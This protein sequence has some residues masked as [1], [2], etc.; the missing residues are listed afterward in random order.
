[1]RKAL[2]G[3]GRVREWLVQSDDVGIE[4]APY[5]VRILDESD[6]PD[7]FPRFQGLLAQ[8]RRIHPGVDLI[9]DQSMDVVTPR[10]AIHIALPVLPDPPREIRRDANVEGA[11]WLARQHVDTGNPFPT[12]RGLSV[13]RRFSCRAL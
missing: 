6:L 2:S 5:R 11:S 3:V 12:H 7:P 1:M 9:P 13:A 4:I 10:K 8:D